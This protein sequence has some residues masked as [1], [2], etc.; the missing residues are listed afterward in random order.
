VAGPVAGTD[1]AVAAVPAVVRRSFYRQHLLAAQYF[2]AAA[3]AAESVWAGG[4][5]REGV[6]QYR[7]LVAASVLSAAAYLEVSVNELHL[8]LQDG[9][10][11]NGRRHSRRLLARLSRE[12][13]LHE[14][15]PTLEKYQFLLGLWD[16]DPFHPRRHP[17]V[18]VDRLMRWRNALVVRF[19]GSTLRLHEELVR[20]P[21]PGTA[22]PPIAPDPVHP[23][24]LRL[25]ARCAR[26]AVQSVVDFSV[27]FCRRMRLP[28]R[29]SGDPAG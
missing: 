24:R 7:D 5:R 19:A 28:A 29:E 10:L 8:E 27:E 20:G 22:R 2:A 23:G 17:Y 6:R 9:A 4:V 18:E 12:W 21:A 11:T 14:R 25:D 3:A 15:A 16:G 26:W 13:R 1:P